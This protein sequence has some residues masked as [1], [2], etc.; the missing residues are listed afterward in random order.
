M[1]SKPSRQV[2][3]FP[4]RARHAR[5][6]PWRAAFSALD[7]R[8]A[9]VERKLARGRPA[10]IE[11]LPPRMR[12]ALVFSAIIHLLIIYG[13]TVRTPDR[14]LFDNQRAQMEVVLVNAKSKAPPVKADAL[15]QHNLDGG[16]N[17]DARRQAQSPLPVLPDQQR[18]TDVKLALRRVEQL[19]REARQLMTQTQSPTQVETTPTPAP[20]AATQPV[21]PETY[22][23]LQASDLRQR[24]IEIAR[25]EAK[26]ARDWD[27]IQQRPR[28]RFIGARTQE[29]RFA[30]Y[31]EDWRQKIERVGELNYPQAARDQKLSGT[32]MVTV[33]IK[34]DG[35]VERV[36]INK[37]SGN[38]ILDEAARRIVQLAAP[39]GAFP[40]DIAKDVDVLHITR[41]WTFTPADRFVSE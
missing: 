22:Q 34:A 41:S 4:R 16:G 19:Q 15:A 28:R 39:F 9:A 2:L 1:A 20:P 24:S 37:P 21:E 17:T 30:R 38:K 23:A 13:V 40:A 5:H 18:E 29:Y 27:E 7:A 14:A 36:D 3:D 8:M 35:S 11:R 32:L 6:T 31:V 12:A 26:I 33:A 25:L 10:A